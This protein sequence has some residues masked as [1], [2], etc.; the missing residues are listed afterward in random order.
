M[1]ATGFIP[2]ANDTLYLTIP[3]CIRINPDCYMRTEI[4]SWTSSCL[5]S[6]T[7]HRVWSTW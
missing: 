5:L 4:S 1:N 3:L 6:R 2:I 7:L